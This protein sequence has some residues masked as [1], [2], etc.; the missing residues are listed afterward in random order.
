MSAR[1]V[2]IAVKL[3]AAIVTVMLAGMAIHAS[4][5]IQYQ[6]ELVRSQISEFGQLLGAQLAQAATAPLFT[7]QNHELAALVTRYAQN[8]RVLGAA[9]YDRDG[10]LVAGA[11]SYPDYERLPAA[12]KA[13]E[14][15][16]PERDVPR[17]LVASL[18]VADEVSFRGA[19]AGTV[20]IALSQQALQHVR[21]QIL[22]YSAIVTAILGAA[23][24]AIAGWLA[25][26]LAR[27]IHTLIAATAA[28][29][30]GRFREV[31]EKRNDEFG[32]LMDAINDMGQG[33]VRKGQVEELMRQ[34]L[35]RDI[36]DKL[37]AN[38]EPVRMGGEKVRATVLFADIVGFTSLSEKMSP[39]EVNSFLNEYFSYLDICARFYFG[40]VDKFIG[41]AV[42]VL[43]GVPRSDPE[44]QYHALACALLMQ[45]LIVRLNQQRAA[46]GLPCATLRIGLNTG[47]MLAGLIGSR[48]RMEYTV[49]G[50]AVNLASRLC[51]EA[52]SGQIIIEQSVFEEVS[53]KH[54]LVVTDS[55][56]VELRGK[57][58]PMRVY[59]ISGIAHQHPLVVDRL[60]DDVLQRGATG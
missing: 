21:R 60:I 26:R 58:A 11:G 45:R 2:P 3:T 34:L 5:T 36:A 8:P 18:I 14:M 57:S 52:E 4:L 40:T 54:P 31:V 24:C 12:G 44:H 42:M 39:E 50:D 49:V 6:Q 9:V 33:L 1:R 20:G 53:Q 27:P 10:K 30:Q 16:L 59:A 43:F 19:V 28:V 32:S 13:R 15:M 29:Q 55:W 51:N 48:M 56:E 35:D 23:F 46:Q 47:D 25:R 17:T 38:V 22:I 37:L 7:D 41:D